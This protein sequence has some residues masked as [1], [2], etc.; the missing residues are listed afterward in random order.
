MSALTYA[1]EHHQFRELI[2]DFVQRSVVPA[3]ET[4]E[5]TG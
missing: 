3:H 2:R 4:W 5:R 1:G